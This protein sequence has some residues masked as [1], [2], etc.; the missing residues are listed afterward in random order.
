M[1]HYL[2][3]HK[4]RSKRVEENAMALGFRE[5]CVD[6]RFS[7]WVNATVA[8]SSRIPVY[9]CTDDETCV[10]PLSPAVSVPIDSVA[11]E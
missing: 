3:S 4:G 2:R 10:A 9:S 6:H 7:L 1:V 8:V 11:I 5:R